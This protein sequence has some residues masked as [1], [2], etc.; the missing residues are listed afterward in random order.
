MSKALTLNFEHTQAGM[1]V[2]FKDNLGGWHELELVRYL[3]P[4]LDTA[5]EELAYI[6]TIKAVRPDMGITV[7][8]RYH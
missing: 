7:Q 5:R 3:S 1:R 2:W 4:T 8:S 6:E